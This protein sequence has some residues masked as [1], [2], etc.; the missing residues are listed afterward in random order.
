MEAGC[1]FAKSYPSSLRL[2]KYIEAIMTRIIKTIKI[3]INMFIL[4]KIKIILF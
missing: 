1:I 2:R 3:Q 4:H